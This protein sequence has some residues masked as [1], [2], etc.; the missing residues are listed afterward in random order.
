MKAAYLDDLRQVKL[1]EE[2]ELQEEYGQRYFE[3][4]S[5]G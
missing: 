4:P 3:V 1:A 5:T 2:N